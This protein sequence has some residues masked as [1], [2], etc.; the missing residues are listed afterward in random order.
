MIDELLA[1]ASNDWSI[2]GLLAEILKITDTAKY[3]KRKLSVPQQRG[4]YRKACRFILFSQR[5]LRKN[6]PRTA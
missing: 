5:F 3:A 4:L 2:I 1:D 6:P